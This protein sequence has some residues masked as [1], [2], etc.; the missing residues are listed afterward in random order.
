MNIETL[1][2]KLTL[3][4]ALLII[5][6][7]LCIIRSIVVWFVPFYIKDILKT[8]KQNQT[9]TAIIKFELKELKKQLNKGNVGEPEK[10]KFLS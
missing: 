3:L 10:E 6:I 1:I 4:I 2:T 8:V 9:D 7:V 5:Y